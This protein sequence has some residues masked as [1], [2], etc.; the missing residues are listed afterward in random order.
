MDEELTALTP[1][2]AAAV[3]TTLTPMQLKAIDLLQQPNL[4]LEDVARQCGVVR[5]T[6]Y[7]WR[8]Q[9]E[10]QAA[11]NTIAIAT[12]E[13]ARAAASRYAMALVEK[14]VKCGLGIERDSECAR[15]AREFILEYAL[16]VRPSAM[17]EEA[18]T[19]YFEFVDGQVLR[20]QRTTP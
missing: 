13:E 9:P 19:E 14:H 8:Q 15:K 5:K 7:K 18:G 20:A 2:T 17:D 11:R 3:D 16:G 12:A 1:A 10:F 6:L 4:S